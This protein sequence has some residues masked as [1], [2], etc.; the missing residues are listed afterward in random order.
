V[1]GPDAPH[2]SPHPCNRDSC[3]IDPCIIEPRPTNR[4]HYFCFRLSPNFALDSPPAVG[5]YINN[6]KR[7]HLMD[8]LFYPAIFGVGLMLLLFHMIHS[9]PHDFF[10]AQ[11]WLGTTTLAVY[12]ASYAAFSGFKS[13]PVRAFLLNLIELALLIACFR[14]L[15]LLDPAGSSAY[16]YGRFAVFL[17]ADILIVQPLWR[18]A[19]FGKFRE[20]LYLLEVRILIVAALR[21]GR[22]SSKMY[23]WIT[24]AIIF[25]LCW[26]EFT[27]EW[28]QRWKTKLFP[29]PRIT[30]INP[31]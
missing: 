12:C 5:T 25:L 27:P 9:A 7:L 19:I 15:G 24:L 3:I 26:Y 31:A 11:F 20:S 13:Y 23:P 21:I 17:S 1:N 28:Y 6:E 10:D 18:Q 16:S 22:V 29:S 14:A 30:P 4:N 8:G 2:S